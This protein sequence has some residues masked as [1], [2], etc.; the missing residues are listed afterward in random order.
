MG[1]TGVICYDVVR[2]GR[3]DK[4]EPHKIIILFLDFNHYSRRTKVTFK[5]RKI[6]FK[7]DPKSAKSVTHKIKLK[8]NRSVG[9]QY[10]DHSGGLPK[11]LFSD[12]YDEQRSEYGAGWD[13][14]IDVSR[15]SQGMFLLNMTNNVFTCHIPQSVSN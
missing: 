15:F 7:I 11:G 10:L 8:K 3:T 5:P 12:W 4:K 6:H 14:T 1:T 13:K 2:Q 9:L